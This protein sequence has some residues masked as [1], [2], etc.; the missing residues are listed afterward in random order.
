[1]KR[2]YKIVATVVTLCLLVVPITAHAE[3]EVQGI[4]TR[5]KSAVLLCM[6]TG[7]M[8]Y[9]Q[10]AHEKLHPASV[11]KVMTML[12][13][14]EAI[15]AGKLAMDEMITASR[16][17][18]EKG[19][20]QIWLKEGEAMSV[21][22]L[23]K[24]IAVVS[25]NDA[26]AALAEKLAGSEEAFVARMNERAKELGMED[27]EFENCTGLDDTTTSHLTSAYDIALMSRELMKHEVIKKFSSIWMDT[28]RDGATELTNTNRLIRFYEGATG[29]KTGTTEKAGSC[30]S[31][32]ATKDGLSFVAVVMGCTTSDD[33]FE[34]AKALLNYGFANF[35]LFTP[36]IEKKQ[37]APIKVLG[38][39]TKQVTP[40]VKNEGPILIK[41][42]ADTGMKQTEKIL[43]QVKAP[44]KAGQSLGQIALQNG[45]EK[46]G[47]IELISAQTIEKTSFVVVIVQLLRLL[48]R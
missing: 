34:G 36:K 38:G 10:N 8:L 22:H 25:A 3:S 1:M 17:A 39:V 32:T 47:T 12:L 20:S 24:A 7:D 27:T 48:V 16:A 15:E 23:L 40:S 45:E 13:I 21:T 14:A 35:S 42:G 4:N 31:A 29:L 9:E 18:C 44:V 46:I 11:T 28:L 30:L 19:G 41:K 43:S 26:S 33:R 5:A 2:F 6:D 37:L